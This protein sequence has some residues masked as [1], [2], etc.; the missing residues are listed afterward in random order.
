M[1]DFS[2]DTLELIVDMAPA[3]GYLLQT[4]IE[5]LDG[6]NHRTGSY[7]RPGRHGVT[8]SSIFYGERLIKLRGKVIGTSAA[9]FEDKR[10][11]LI[12]AL[13]VTK[14]ENGYPTP[15]R[16]SFT[17]LAGRSYYVDAYF[18][19]PIMDLYTPASC[20]FMVTAL[21]GDSFIYGATTVNSGNISRP[22]GGGYVVP[23]VLPYD[24]APSSGGT[25]TVTNDGTE[26]SLPL[27][28][29]TGLLTNP[30]I[31]NDTTGKFI[32]LEYT[33]ASGDTAVIDMNELLITLNDS[34]S[35]IGSK[36]ITSDWWGIAPG[37]NSISITTDS[38]S[39]DGFA[40]LSFNAAYLGI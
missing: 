38:P 3:N 19:K 1:Q 39:D 2:I 20:E 30:I 37:D 32:Q 36:T 16:L 7:S 10:Q 9:D 24:S 6:P 14:D 4:P 22:S 40:T 8:V 27:I 13:A 25:I 18:D 21:V 31:T 29:L 17:T 15:T 5:G 11:A 26:E 28:T 33:L 23:M 34:A 35:L 12:N